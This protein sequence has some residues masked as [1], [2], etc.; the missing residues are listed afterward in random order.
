MDSLF[1]I[2]SLK[3]PQGYLPLYLYI[4]KENI[5]PQEFSRIFMILSKIKEQENYVEAQ[6]SFE[7]TQK[8]FN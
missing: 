7:T 2:Y 6:S 5:N 8:T 1:S 3:Q 4:V